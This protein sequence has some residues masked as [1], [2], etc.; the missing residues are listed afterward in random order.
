ML[1]FAAIIQIVLRNENFTPPAVGGH[2]R[3]NYLKVRRIPLLCL[4]PFRAPQSADLNL[5]WIIVVS[6]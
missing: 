3:A 6:R 1:M 4:T 5:T 2:D